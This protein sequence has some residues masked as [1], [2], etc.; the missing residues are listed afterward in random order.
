MLEFAL[1][2]RWKSERR[3]P[4]ACQSALSAI[5]CGIVATICPIEAQAGTA[6]GNLTVQMTITGSCTIGAATLNFGSDAGAA[7]LTAGVNASTTVSVTCTNGS[8]YSI[9]MDN[10][11]NYLGTRRMVS[12][13]AYIGYGLF[14]DSA[15]T[16][17]WSTT[18][19]A[20]SCTGGANTCALSV[21]NGSAQSINIYGAVPT[22]A[23]APAAGSYSDTV[24][25]TI[26][27]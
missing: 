4:H 1:S 7:L 13:G 12:S 24:T 15:D 20:S 3:F 5:A 22:V 8:P 21:G 18:T 25:M 17:A 10:G 6:T 14:L 9:G 16:E 26:T 11:Q 27:Y 19:S 23:T 2:Q